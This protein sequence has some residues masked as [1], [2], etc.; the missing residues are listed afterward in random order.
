MNNNQTCRE[1]RE[2]SKEMLSLFTLGLRDGASSAKQSALAL[3]KLM[4]LEDQENSLMWLEKR[5]AIYPEQIGSFLELISDLYRFH[6]KERI[7][8]A[9]TG[10]F[11]RT[12]LLL[13]ARPEFRLP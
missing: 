6:E 5:L 2:Y 12:G 3:Y 9:N 4:N 10:L 7:F 11:M 13:A 1:F 8:L